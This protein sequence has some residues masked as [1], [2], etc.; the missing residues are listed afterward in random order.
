M[1]A[2]GVF[3]RKAVAVVLAVS[4]VFPVLLREIHLSAPYAPYDTIW[5]AALIALMLPDLARTPWRIPRRWRVP[6]VTAVLIVAAT[7]PIVVLRE[8]DLNPGLLTD[9]SAWNWAGTMWPA[10][11]VTWMLH[12]ALTLVVGVLWFDWLFGA[13]DLDFERFVVTPLVVSVAALVAVSIHQLVVDVGFLNPTVYASIGRASGTMYDANVSG[14]IAAMWIGGMFLRARNLPRYRSTVVALT[15]F[16][17]WLAVWATGSRTAFLLA[18]VSTLSIFIALLVERGRPRVR[19]SQVVT[20]V[21]AVAVF[22]IIVGRFSSHTR[23]PVTRLRA[24]LP[25]PTVASVK[26]FTV[27]MWN[28]NQ[29]G[30]A[31]TAMIRDVPLFGVGIGTYHYLGRDYVGGMHWQPDNAQNWIRHQVAEL[32]VVGSAGW[33]VW[34]VLFGAF[35]FRVR[36]GDTSVTWVTRCTL[37]AFAGIS[38]LGMPAQNVMVAMTFWTIAFWHVLSLEPTRPEPPLP[39]WVW[40]IAVVVPLVAAMG[41]TQLAMT[42][43]RVPVRTL[44]TER[45][46][47]YGFSGPDAAAGRDGYRAAQSHAVVVLDAPHEWLSISVRRNDQARTPVDVRVWTNGEPLLKGRLAGDAPLTAVVRVPVSLRRVLLETAARS[48]DSRRPFFVRSAESLYLVKWEFLERAPTN[49][50]GYSKQITS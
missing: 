44:A 6:L 20:V 18:A 47:S 3:Q 15:T 13:V 11:L 32:G 8:V 36:R 40:S 10:T 21:A 42:R 35:V 7:S 38:M 1:L 14:V 50:H 5:T 23:D 29:Y 37:A 48:S 9:R 2:L 28:R 45:R 33:I 43:L 19:L 46:Y 49:V 12:V 24:Q 31:A 39:G 27:E 30:S 22:L 4:Y 26:H 25:A 17:A 34:F 41:T 16:A